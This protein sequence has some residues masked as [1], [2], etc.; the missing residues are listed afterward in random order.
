MK[1]FNPIMNY[2]SFDKKYIKFLRKYVYNHWWQKEHKIDQAFLNHVSKKY[3]VKCT[4]VQDKCLTEDEFVWGQIYITNTKIKQ[5]MKLF[6]YN[7]YKI[8]L[9]DDDMNIVDEFLNGL[10]EG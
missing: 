8:Y 7:G 5:Y 10:I 3:N 6:N 4:L 9:V 1:V 2:R